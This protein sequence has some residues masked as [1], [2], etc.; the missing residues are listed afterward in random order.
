MSLLSN[1]RLIRTMANISTVLFVMVIVLQIFLAVGILPITMAWGGGQ[2]QLTASLR[3]SRII[4]AV[5]LGAFIYV[6][7]YRA[8]LVGTVRIPVFMKVVSWIITAI[9]A[10][11]TL[12]NIA[13]TSTVE[14]LIFGPITL[15]LAVACLLVLASRPEIR[16][17]AAE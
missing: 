8:G 14:K 12:G 6:I 11:N 9:M 17:I 13:S 7:R 3:I 2:S 4:A 1:P 10:L 5:L 15:I 16:S